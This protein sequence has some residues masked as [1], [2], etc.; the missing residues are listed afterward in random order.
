[1]ARQLSTEQPF[2]LVVGNISD[3][4]KEKPYYGLLTSYGEIMKAKCIF[5]KKEDAFP[6]IPEEV[7]TVVYIAPEED[8]REI[9]A[10]IPSNVRFIGYVNCTEG[11]IT[12][13]CTAY[14]G[15]P[16]SRN[17]MQDMDYVPGMWEVVYPHITLAPPRTSSDWSE[18]SKMVGSSITF[19]LESKCINTPNTILNRAMIRNEEYHVTRCVANGKHPSCAEKELKE[20][21]KKESTEMYLN[22]VGYPVLM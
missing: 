16:V 21:K 7:G 9:L 20:M 10:T 2:M 3:W 6:L 22:L 11:I 15:I 18:Y 13:N 1:M 17:Y 4:D 8:I 12:S 14:V 5:M 19:K